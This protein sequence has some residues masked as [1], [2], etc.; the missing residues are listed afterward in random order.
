MKLFWPDPQ[1]GQPQ[2]S[3]RVGTATAANV[4]SAW[5]SAESNLVPSNAV[6]LGVTLPAAMADV[7]WCDT[8]SRCVLSAK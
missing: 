4:P 1:R 3:V 8:A 6:E 5:R 7:G 2:M